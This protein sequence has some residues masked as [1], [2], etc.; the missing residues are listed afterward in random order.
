[1]NQAGKCSICSRPAKS[2]HCTSCSNRAD[3]LAFERNITP[4]AAFEFLQRDRSEQIRRS[5]NS[6]VAALRYQV[7]HSRPVVSSD[8]VFAPNKTVSDWQLRRAR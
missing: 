3:D 1:M 6:D 8:I 5:L 7:R 2:I 4:D